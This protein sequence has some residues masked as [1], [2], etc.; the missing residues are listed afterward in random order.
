MIN[1]N[2]DCKRRELQRKE[3]KKKTTKKWIAKNNITWIQEK[4]FE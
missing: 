3:P 2:G 1:E 4:T